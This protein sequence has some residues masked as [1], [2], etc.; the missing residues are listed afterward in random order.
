[1]VTIALRLGVGPREIPDTFYTALVQGDRSEDGRAAISACTIVARNYIP[2]A[3][4]VAKSF[5]AH[6]PGGQFFVLFLDDPLGQID[7]AY[8]P[9]EVLRL[10]DLDIE[11]TDLDEMAAAYS[12]MEF[13]TAVKPWLLST[14][15]RR[16]FSSVLYIDPDIQIFHSLRELSALAEEHAIVLTPHATAPMPRDG[17]MITETSIL[18]SGIYNLGFV[19]VGEQGHAFLQF[20]M[21]RLRRE[22]YVDPPNMRFVDQRWVDF[23]PGMFDC[24]IVRDPGYNVAYWNLDHRDLTFNGEFYEVDGAPLKFFHFSGYSPNQPHLLSKHQLA[25]SPRILLSER[26]AVRRICDE[27]SGLLMANGFGVDDT[28][29]YGLDVMANGVPLDRIVRL[30]YRRWLDE[31]DEGEG[32]YPP[33]PFTPDG[34]AELVAILNRPPGVPDDPGHL[35]VYQATLFGLRDDVRK[36]IHDPQGGDRQRFFDWLQA[37]AGRGGLHP[38]LAQPPLPI[39]HGA[40]PRADLPEPA[41]GDDLQPGVTLVGYL[42]AELGV[43][44]GARLLARSLEAS[45]IPY[46]TVVSTATGSRQQHAFVERPPESGYKFDINIVCINADQLPAFAAE[47]GPGFFA[48]HYTIGQWAWELE[49]FPQDQHVA[50]DAVDEVWAISEF[51]RAAIAAATTKPVFALPFPI[52]APTV[53][54]GIGRPELNLPDDR[55][56]FLFCFDFFSVLE[57]KNPLGLVEA[58]RR[59]FSPDD[60]ALLILKVVNGDKRVA[61]LEALRLAIADRPD[62]QLIDKYFDASHLAALMD[63]AD[64]YVSLHRSEGFG[65]TMAEAM[66]LGKPVIATAYSGN[67]DFMNNEVAYLVRWT[68]GTVPPGCAPYPIGAT[69]ADPDLDE[70][71]RLLRRVFDHPDEAAAVGHRAKQLVETRHGPDQRVAFVRER[72]AAIE[73]KRAEALAA[74]EP[75]RTVGPIPLTELAAS[76][77]SLDTISK[78][79]PNLSRFYRRA[80]LRAQRHHDDH[81]RQVNVALAHAVT[82]LE[83]EVVRL[84]EAET[85]LASDLDNSGERTRLAVAQSHRDISRMVAEQARAIQ[86]HNVQQAR[87]SSEA[88]GTHRALGELDQSPDQPASPPASDGRRPNG[89]SVPSSV[90]GGRRVTTYPSGPSGQHGP[91]KPE[92][93]F[94][95]TR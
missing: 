11:R 75:S 39:H 29:P 40:S 79:F 60:G 61:D 19:G 34:A 2:A 51:T 63:A 16:G 38:V 22:C 8:E 42:R 43:G 46:T 67:M 81:Q 92:E 72:F 70:A 15:L 85:M 95:T 80:V 55:T 45:D 24:A 93:S 32:P 41:L 94:P 54:V 59:A 78:R 1:V 44:Q 48:D 76:R 23:A 57:R 52:V 65:L 9:F 73:T 10:A 58:Y 91:E 33:N 25:D 20:W 77:P 47:A 87:L 37:E 4:V 30:L 36:L 88:A 62:I 5:M 21:D 13:A 53:P 86:S 17:K 56:V 69:W 64:C 49:D 6:H 89:D 74:V 26:P 7:S 3:R 14:L 12:V 27:Y 18:A 31:A 82:R 83:H 50:F 71:A 66:A 68:K 35:T 90:E 84:E 28:A